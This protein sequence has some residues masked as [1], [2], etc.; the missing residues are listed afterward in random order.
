MYVADTMCDQH[1]HTHTHTEI[2]MPRSDL[3]IITATKPKADD[4]FRTAAVLSTHI[5]QYI[6]FV[7]AVNFSKV[8]Y[9]ISL[10]DA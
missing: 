1:P 7:T 4:T 3:F 8:Y 6:N 2:H 9:Q 5:L 10:Q